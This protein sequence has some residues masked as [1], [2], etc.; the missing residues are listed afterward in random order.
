MLALWALLSHT[1]RWH[2]NESSQKKDLRSFHI[3]GFVKGLL[4]PKNDPSSGQMATYWWYP[5]T[6]LY[7]AVMIIFEFGNVMRNKR[8]A[9]VLGMTA[10][11]AWDVGRGVY[12]RGGGKRPLSLNN[13]TLLSWQGGRGTSFA[14]GDWGQRAKNL[15]SSTPKNARLLHSCTAGSID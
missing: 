8:S 11:S 5:C 2:F 10:R 6:S 12:R 15:F 13:L 4:G 1:T 3:F 7:G 9:F 14:R